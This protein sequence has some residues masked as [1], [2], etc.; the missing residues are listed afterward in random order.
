MTVTVNLST[1]S[2]LSF[3][4]AQE[5]DRQLLLDLRRECG[6]GAPK[7]QQFLGYPDR[8]FCIFLL[9]RESGE[10]EEVGMGGWCLD[11]DDDQETASRQRGI[12]YISSLFIRKAYQ[13]GGLG[14][15]AIDLL[16]K[17]AVEVYGAKVITLDTTAYFT[18][19]D[20]EGWLVEDFNRRGRAV[21]WYEKRGYREYRDPEPTFPHASRT[22]PDRKLQAV[23][24]RKSV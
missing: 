12:V 9:E 23:F 15:K 22:D 19:V 17:A 20:E 8:P 13:A 6:W 1:K 18:Y 7:I 24:M 10:V 2:T 4:I 21:A 14:T 5:E 3:R 16:E 11:M